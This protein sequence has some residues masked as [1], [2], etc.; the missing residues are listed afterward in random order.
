VIYLQPIENRN[1]GAERECPFCGSVQIL[2]R[3]HLIP[4]EYGGSD[5]PRNLLM[6]CWDCHRLIHE[7]FDNRKLAQ[8]LNTFEKLKIALLREKPH[9]REVIVEVASAGAKSLKKALNQ[10]RDLCG[11]YWTEEGV[12]SREGFLPSEEAK[13]LLAFLKGEGGSYGSYRG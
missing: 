13:E 5:L 4:V 8:E 12:V 3:H 9:K 2:S 6:I 10:A 1:C 11:M 7:R